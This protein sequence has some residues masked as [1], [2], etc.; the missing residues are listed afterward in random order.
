MDAASTDL[1]RTVHSCTPPEAARLL[2]TLCGVDFDFAEVQ[3]MRKNPMYMKDYIEHL[4][5]IQSAIGEKLMLDAGKFS[6]DT[7]LEKA[8][9]EYRKYQVRTLF[10][11]EEVYLK[12]IQDTEKVVKNQPERTVKEGKSEIKFYDTTVSD[13]RQGSRH[14][15][16]CRSGVQR[17][18]L[19]D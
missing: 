18:K 7:V 4:D 3:A 16:L 10:P 5:S 12:T 8:T 13:R 9:V 17:N 11:V 15:G 6:H 19:F 2:A 1:M 14:Q